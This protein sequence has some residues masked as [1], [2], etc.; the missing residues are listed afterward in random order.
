MNLIDINDFNSEAMANPSDDREIGY[1]SLS[2]MFSGSSFN[3]KAAGNYNS[4]SNYYDAEVNSNID[5]IAVKADDK[6]KEALKFYQ[7]KHDDR[8]MKYLREALDDGKIFKDATGI[9]QGKT[10]HFKS[11]LKNNANAKVYL[12]SINDYDRLVSL[13]GGRDNKSLKADSRK[14]AFEDYTRT[15]K[16][17]SSTNGILPSIA[18]FVGMM[19]GGLSD[20]AN[21]AAMAIGGP[22]KLAGTGAKALFSTAGK[23]AVQ[24]AKIGLGFEL[25][26]APKVY[27]WKSQIGVDHSIKDAVIESAAS[28]L[29]GSTIRAGGS[30]AVDISPMVLGKL[31]SKAKLEGDVASENLINE[32]EAMTKDKSFI[33]T[34]DHIDAMAE[35][36]RNIDDGLEAKTQDFIND[37]TDFTK[38]KKEL[39]ELEARAKV[40]AKIEEVGVEAAA[41]NNRLN[42][43]N[44]IPMQR[45]E[46]DATA[47]D[48]LFEDKATRA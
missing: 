19:A 32:Y 47:T 41:M 40:Q 20:P 21:I 9:Y 35:A 23:A 45:N 25:L 43:L 46:T 28:I 4:E 34:E 29:M 11:I 18:G 3:I 2:D 26:T 36:R 42:D 16:R 8:D 14:K 38:I 5:S 24:E 6:E 22:V 12:Q 48:K 15:Q 27:D 30:L 7:S 37:T 33:N 10:N 39:D 13:H 1:K 44:Q 17:I 31:K